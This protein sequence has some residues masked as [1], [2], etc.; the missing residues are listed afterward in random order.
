MLIGA[1][2][3]GGLFSGWAMIRLRLRACSQEYQR[4]VVR[5]AAE[6]GIAENLFQRAGAKMLPP[7]R[8]IFRR[9]HNIRPPGLPSPPIQ[10][11]PFQKRIDPSPQVKGKRMTLHAEKQYL[12]RRWSN[13]ANRAG[14]SLLLPLRLVYWNKNVCDIYPCA[15]RRQN[16]TCHSNCHTATPKR[17]GG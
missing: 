4:P 9:H 2:E 1:L 13:F 12:G 17:P 11:L 3:I 5:A 7:M 6:I 15:G 14:K 10:I 8:H 16:D